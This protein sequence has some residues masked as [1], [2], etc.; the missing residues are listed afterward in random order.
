MRKYKWE[1]L[2]QF[3]DAS[4]MHINSMTLSFAQIEQIINGQLP[5]G[6]YKYRAGWADHSGFARARGWLPDWRTGPVNLEE[7][8]VTFTRVAGGGTSDHRK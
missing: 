2:K 3:L 5:P 4:P 8:W 1:P 7:Q 6:A